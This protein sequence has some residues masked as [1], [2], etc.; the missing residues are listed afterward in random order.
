MFEKSCQKKFCCYLVQGYFFCC[1]LEES[2]QFP[3]ANTLLPHQLLFSKNKKMSVIAIK[4]SKEK[5]INLV[6]CFSAD[7]SY[8]T[9]QFLF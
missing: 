4:Q 3:C 7:Y 1:Y 9:D 8:K 5:Q 2:G 6:I